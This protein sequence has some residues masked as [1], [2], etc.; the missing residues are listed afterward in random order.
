[1]TSEISMDTQPGKPCV[2]NFSLRNIFPRALFRCPHYEFEDIIR[3]IDSAVLLAPEVDPSS[4]RYTFAE[5][6]AYHAP[7]ALN[8]G[9]QRIPAKTHYDIFFMFC[10]FPQELLIFNSISNVRDICRISVCLVV[11]LWLKQMVKLRLFLRILAKFDV[12]LLY[13]SQSVKPLSEQIG[14]RCVFLPPGVDAILFCRQPN[15]PNR[16]IDACSMGRRSEVTDRRL[17][18]MVRE[19]G[20]FYLHD[21]I[22]GHEAINSK[23]HSSLLANVA[24]R[25][26]Y[27]F[28]NPRK[29]H[30]P[31]THVNQI[32]I[33]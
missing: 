5:R 7:V 9:I 20:L 14:R 17:L 31:N 3:E 33:P 16:V 22:A 13:Y 8:P 28:F 26:P 32:E 18:R 24:K 15:P 11:E 23:E 12:V 27:F 30:K 6:L 1:M 10:G 2:L 21:S 25:S 29:I 19:S 4:T